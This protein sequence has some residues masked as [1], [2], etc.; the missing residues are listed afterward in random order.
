MFFYISLTPISTTS[1]LWSTG[2][3]HKYQQIDVYI[4]Q[5]VDDHSQLLRACFPSSRC[6]LMQGY[7]LIQYFKLYKRVK[8]RIASKVLSM[9]SS[10]FYYFHRNETCKWQCILHKRV[11]S[12]LKLLYPNTMKNIYQLLLMRT[13]VVSVYISKACTGKKRLSP[14]FWGKFFF[15]VLL[16]IIYNVHIVWSEIVNTC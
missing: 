5:C 9:Q 3:T 8:E 13:L 7:L 4:Y 1:G 14:Q 10:C 2:N 11:Y 16:C 6:V 15:F 12:Q